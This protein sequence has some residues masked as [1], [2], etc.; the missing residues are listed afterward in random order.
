MIKITTP[1]GDLYLEELNNREEDER[2]K[3]Y[4]SKR[5]YLDYF[6]TESMD[7][8]ETLEAYANRIIVNLQKQYTVEALLAHLCIDAYTVSE[9][10][11]DLLEDIFG[12]DKYEYDEQG[13]YFLLSDGSEINEENLMQNE[14]INKIGKTFVFVCD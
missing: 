6:S 1:V 3:L 2:I 11:R 7:D 8:N 10:W 13:R 12:S 5:R 14:Y 4:D 9:D